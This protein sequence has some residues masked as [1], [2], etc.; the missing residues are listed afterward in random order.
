MTGGRYSLKYWED[1]SEPPE[2]R[3]LM[4]LEERLLDPQVRG[5]RY[6]L[7]ALLR[8]DF[9]EIGSSGR[10][11]DKAYLIDSMPEE[12]HVPIA[13]HGMKARLLGDGVGIVTYRTVGEGGQVYRSSVWMKE[14][15]EG[16]WQLV[17]HQG[18]RLPPGWRPRG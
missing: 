12:E 5:D 7:S 16:K 13:T 10:T 14:K 6:A 4:M 18:T 2:L 8:D 11:Y 17:F 1:D 3:H 15:D 9:T